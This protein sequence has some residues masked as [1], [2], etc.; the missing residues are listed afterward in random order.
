M[1]EEQMDEFV[2]KI[3]EL[4][5]EYNCQIVP[6][7]HQQFRESFIRGEVADMTIS[8]IKWKSQPPT[9]F[10][11]IVKERQVDGKSWKVNYDGSR[12]RSF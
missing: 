2:N 3:K 5:K 10:L 9:L 4:A 7:T 11:T 1:T 6:E 8:L 12:W